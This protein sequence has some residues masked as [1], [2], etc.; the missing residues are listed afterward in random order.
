MSLIDY[1]VNNVLLLLYVQVETGRMFLGKYRTYDG[2]W[3]VNG[4]NTVQFLLYCLRGFEWVRN[5]V[6]KQH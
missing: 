2:N 3:A 6:R 4:F 1:R 5:T